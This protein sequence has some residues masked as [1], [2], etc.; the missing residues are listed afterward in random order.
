M[1]GI[2]GIYYRNSERSYSPGDKSIDRMLAHLHHRG[3]DDL[4]LYINR[5]ISFGNA[6]LAI[7]DL[8]PSAAQ[9][10]VLDNGDFAITYNGEIYNYL[11]L[12]KSLEESGV[13]F[14]SSSDTEVLLRLYMMKGIACLS[15]LRGMFAFAIWDRK[16]RTLFLARDRAGEKPLVYF[17]RHDIFAFASEINALLGVHGLPREIDPLGLHYGLHYVNVPAP[18]S[19]FKHIRKLKPSHYMLVTDDK[20]STKRYWTPRY[21]AASLIHNPREAVHAINKCLDE[22]VRI[23]CRSDVPIGA[24]LSGGLDSSAVAA[25]MKKKLSVFDTFCVSHCLDDTDPEFNAARLVAEMLRTHHHELTFNEDQLATAAE[26]VLGYGEPVATFVPLHA[27]ALAALIG[28]FLKVVLTGN[29]GDELFGGY[30]DHRILLR[31]QKKLHLWHCF[32]K[33]KVSRLLPEDAFTSIQRSREKYSGLSKIPI[34]RIAALL[35][36]RNADAFCNEVYTNKMKALTAEHDPA[37]LLVNEFNSYGA[38][39]I[40][41]GFLVQQ[42][43]IGSQ[44][45]VVDIPDISGMT[46]SLEYRSPFLDVK[47][48]ELAMRIPEFMKVRAHRGESGGKW[49][50]RKAMKNRLPRNIVLMKKA[51]FGSVIPYRRWMVT[52]WAGYVESMLMRPS[53]LD[54][55][56]FD[57][58]KLIDLF[59]QA[60]MGKTMPLEMIWGVVMISQWLAIYF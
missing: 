37:Q 35:R 19:A 52:D 42:L 49:I 7:I 43:M 48:M 28:D 60:R 11:E 51:G 53:F 20:L 55:G 45:S 22:T 8:S 54:T 32:E 3:P 41:D 16:K 9:P 24:T 2:C 38:A 47:M 27:H 18:Y 1:C 12:R 50:L 44:H 58:R 17:Q 56:L 25:S 33:W 5:P 31:L 34:N 13:K 15:D 26:V 36:L 14:I 29:G 39:N 6:R 21:S 4:G 46:H 59:T 23:M 40:F 30:A 57:S 10:M